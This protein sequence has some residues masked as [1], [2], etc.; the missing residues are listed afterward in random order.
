MKVKYLFILGCLVLLS[1]TQEFPEIK[2][3]VDEF[4]KDITIYK[5]GRAIRKISNE[6]TFPAELQFELNSMIGFDIDSL[7]QVLYINNYV[8]ELLAVS[9]NDGQILYR[10]NLDKI[11]FDGEASH[12]NMK[13]K[14]FHIIK[15]RDKLLL[16]TDWDVL[17]YNE[18]LQLQKKLL[19]SVALLNPR[20]PKGFIGDFNYTIKEDSI[21]LSYH[22]RSYR[23]GLDDL[24]KL[25]VIENFTFKL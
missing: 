24:S 15:Y 21:Q 19:D 16:T 1:C 22:I 10:S 4:G 20:I 11:N 23:Y 5:N 18:K 12:R 7:N 6:R 9:L 3:D 8:K 17:V 2:V 13:G 14:V 25:P